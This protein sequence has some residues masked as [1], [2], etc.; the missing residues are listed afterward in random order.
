MHSDVEKV[1]QT[2][3]ILGKRS[4]FCESQCYLYIN[5]VFH[6]SDSRVIE[7]IDLKLP[8]LI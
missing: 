1:L 5:I 6:S 8:L 3:T 4:V 2:K 7:N